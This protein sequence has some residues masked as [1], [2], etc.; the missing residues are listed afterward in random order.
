MGTEALPDLDVT[1]TAFDAAQQELLVDQKYDRDDRGNLRTA[2]PD[3]SA[4]SR[5]IA[6]W[7]NR[8]DDTL[9]AIQRRFRGEVTIG[10]H[11]TPA[12]DPQASLNWTAAASQVY[13]R[14]VAN[15]AFRSLRLLN[16]F[17]GQG[18]RILD[19]A[20]SPEG[21]ETAIGGSICAD[22]ANRTAWVKTTASG[23][24]GWVDL[25][26]GGKIT[27]TLGWTASASALY[28]LPFGNNTEAATLAAQHLY[29]VP[30]DGTLSAVSIVSAADLGSTDLY[31]RDSGGS[32]LASVLGA[33]SSAEGSFF[34]TTFAPALDVSAGDVIALALD[35]SNNSGQT[36]A[37]MEID[38][39]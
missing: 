17:L 11:D 15:S 1:P 3:S 27:E 19:R 25:L 39:R 2:Y 16:L 28:Y 37:V 38:V 20:G 6:A 29:R 26:A 14:N 33:T 5:F 32:N 13:L 7:G 30:A 22:T 12:D 9:R 18:A 35:T 21:A 23:N 34:V 4:V 24:T 10:T 31:V 36:T 8:V